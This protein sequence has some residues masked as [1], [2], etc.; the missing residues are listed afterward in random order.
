M[1]LVE[2]SWGS[3]MA[4]GVTCDRAALKQLVR[5]GQVHSKDCGPREVF[6]GVAALL[7]GEGLDA[8]LMFGAGQSQRLLVL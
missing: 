8:V 6:W 2:P 4:A 3:L 7:Q 5:I 1:L